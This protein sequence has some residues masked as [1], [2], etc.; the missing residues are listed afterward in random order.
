M[1]AEI[2]SPLP[3]TLQERFDEL[4][5][6]MRTHAGAME[7]VEF[8][9]A[10]VLTVRF[11]AMCQGCPF[12]SV[13]LYGLVKPALEELPEV[14]EVRALG[15]RVSEES[16]RMAAEAMGD[17]GGWLPLSPAEKGLRVVR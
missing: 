16:A 13:T 12:R 3:A 5:V 2:E 1:L 10:G 6:L 14:T 9:D 8:T 11:L 17:G 7:V 15:V 4:N